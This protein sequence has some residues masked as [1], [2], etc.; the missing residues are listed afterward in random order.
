MQ[1][2][3]CNPLQFSLDTKIYLYNTESEYGEIIGHVTTASLGTELPRL[4]Y[5]KEANTIILQGDNEYS[6]QIEREIKT[7]IAKQYANDNI[8]VIIQG[9]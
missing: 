6:R 2:I 1:V 9:E 5:L 4:A 3:I 7:E 8:Q